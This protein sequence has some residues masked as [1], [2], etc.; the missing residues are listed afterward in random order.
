MNRVAEHH[1]HGRGSRV[2]RR[3]TRHYARTFYFASH[4]LPRETRDHAYAIYGFCRW[5]DNGVDDAADLRAAE[6]RLA[7]ARDALDIAYSGRNSGAALDSFRRTVRQRGIPRSLFEDLLDGMAMDLTVTRY[8]DEAT[9]DRYCYRVA[10]V[11]GLMMTHLFGYR[12]ARCLPR[13]IALG[14]AMQR[15]NILRDVGEDLARG[16]IYLPATAL[17]EHRLG[18]ADLLAGR[19]DDRFR[20]L[21]RSQMAR[22]RALYAE[23]EAGVADLIGPAS[24]LT[25][26]VMGRLY[27]E[28]LAAIEGLDYDVFRRRASVPL[29]RKLQLLAA[30]QSATWTES[31]ARWLA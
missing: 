14:N 25:V 18:E 1:G 8:A 7:L 27:A 17:A 6:S 3:I 13:A 22:T 19:V 15:T 2:C 24:R 28:I 12:H 26:R 9:L 4:C 23:A 29:A 11:V 31:T 21:M 30:C 20:S 16:R 10:G 5:V